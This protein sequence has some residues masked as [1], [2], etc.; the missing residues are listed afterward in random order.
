MTG[1]AT[2][3]DALF[4]AAAGVEL[5]EAVERLGMKSNDSV[6]RHLLRHGVEVPIHWRWEP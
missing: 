4:L 5:R 1:C 6:R 3:E 2:C